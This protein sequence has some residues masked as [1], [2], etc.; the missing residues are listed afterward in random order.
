MA[1]MVD[2]PGSHPAS[3][4]S[5]DDVRRALR[6]PLPGLPAQ[7]LLAPAYRTAELQDRTP[8]ATPREAGVLVLLYPHGDR[9]FFPLTRR[10]QS[11]ANHRGQVSLPGGA[12]E[13]DESLQ[14]TAWR[15]TCEE[16]GVCPDRWDSLG[17]LSPLYIPPS[18]FR[19]HPFVAYVPRHPRFHPDPLEVAEVIETPLAFLV[20]PSS[21]RREEWEL[22]GNDVEVP[23]FYVKGHKV[24]GATAM[25]LSELVFLLREY[26]H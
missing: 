5:V 19:I 23:F 20:D 13:G 3:P 8:H 10:T 2:E 7:V 16:L 11:V 14:E 25:V 1:S 4:L 21:V 17:S 12:Q 6:Q 26:I 15:E 24:W 9:L 18:G 22:H